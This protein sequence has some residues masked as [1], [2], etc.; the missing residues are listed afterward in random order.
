[1]TFLLNHPSWIFLFCNLQAEMGSSVA[2]LIAQELKVEQN[3][4][5]NLAF[6][7][8]I[9]LSV[10]AKEDGF[11]SSCLNSLR[12][13]LKSIAGPISILSWARGGSFGHTLVY[14]CKLVIQSDSSMDA[15]TSTGF[16][17]TGQH[18]LNKSGTKCFPTLN[19]SSYCFIQFHMLNV[20]VRPLCSCSA[21]PLDSS[22]FRSALHEH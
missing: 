17:K 18:F 22:I 3:G 5:T 2:V 9:W 6:N 19:F 7:P 10:C 14:Y 4:R 16:I 20:S 13:T 1:M 15:A 21:V 11:M 12:F 8:Q